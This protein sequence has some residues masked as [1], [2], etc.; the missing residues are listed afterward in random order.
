V[1]RLHAV[2]IERVR[3]LVW[4]LAASIFGRAGLG[5]IGCCVTGCSAAGEQPPELGRV[6]QRVLGG[7]AVP[8]SEWGSVGWLDSGCTAVQI[9]DRVLAY[10][11]HCGTDASFAWFQ[12]D[13][14]INGAKTESPP[15]KA[16][17]I[18]RCVAHPSG[19]EIGR[20]LAVCFLAEPR[21]GTFEPLVS[22][23]TRSRI[24][25]GDDALLLGYGSIG[26]GIRTLT[27]GAVW[28]DIQDVGWEL[29][30]GDAEHGTCPGDSGGPAFVSTE[31]GFELL[32]V[33]SGGEAEHCG[34]G[35]YTDLFAVHDWLDSQV[36][37]AGSSEP[38]AG[39]SLSQRNALPLRH[40]SATLLLVF[41]FGITVLLSL[42]RSRAPSPPSS[43]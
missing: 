23:T 2:R 8:A 24:E 16:F 18:E 14:R 22:E 31:E 29:Y 38:Q 15:S 11:A 35:W 34:V 37:Q 41:A 5:L 39:C 7:D 17:R 3:R 6:S 43:Q 1:G 30:I 21:R 26:S 9:S 28:A 36:E 20:D 27:K 40:S 19:N 25:P 12:N 13:I 33:L 32:A 10:A 4:H 42:R